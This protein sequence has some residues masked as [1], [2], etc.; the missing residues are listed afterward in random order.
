M[1][2]ILQNIRKYGTGEINW[3]PYQRKKE[4]IWRFLNFRD[5]NTL[6]ATQNQNEKWRRFLFYP[7]NKFIII[8]DIISLVF[9]IYFLSFMPVLIVFNYNN[10]FLDIF[11]IIVDCF[12][13]IDIFIN[14][15]LTYKKKN[16]CFESNRKVI[17]KKYLKSYF[18]IDF[19]TS[20]PISLILSSSSIN[21]G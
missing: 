13:I 11:E 10:E 17:V 9:L 20:L 21:S 8:W 14:F 15:N 5:V 16:G 6:R 7:D 18:I 2:K 19:F 4:D 3:D 1:F 12:F